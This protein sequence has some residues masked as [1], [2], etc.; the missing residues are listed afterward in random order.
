MSISQ[1]S[2]NVHS[3]AMAMTEASAHAAVTASTAKLAIRRTRKG[4]REWNRT[5][6]DAFAEACVRMLSIN[7]A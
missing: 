1:G 3:N 2:G 6:T 4:L 7:A 5:L